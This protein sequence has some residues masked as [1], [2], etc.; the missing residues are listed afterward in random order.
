MNNDLDISEMFE[1]T[2]KTEAEINKQINDAD[3]VKVDQIIDIF[4]WALK[5][6]RDA[7]ETMFLSHTLT[8]NPTPFKEH[9]TLFC[10]PY[11]N[12]IYLSILGIL[13]GAIGEN[14]NCY[15]GYDIDSE[16]GHILRFVKLRLNNDNSTYY[17]KENK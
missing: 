14:N 17:A 10:R 13:N 3:V 2:I 8:K 16:T 9:P 5:H 15:I 11:N 7:V 1:D 6:D 4:N 12:N